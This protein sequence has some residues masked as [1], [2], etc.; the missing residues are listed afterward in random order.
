MCMQVL[1]SHHDIPAALCKKGRKRCRSKLVNQYVYRNV[2]SG[3]NT[4]RVESRACCDVCYIW[5][6]LSR[7]FVRMAL[8][9]TG[10]SNSNSM[11]SPA[12]LVVSTLQDLQVQLRRMEGKQAQMQTSLDEIKD[13]LK[14]SPESN[15]KVKGS[16]FQVC[17]EIKL[18]LLKPV[19][20]YAL[21]AYDICI[22]I[23]HTG[24]ETV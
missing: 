3:A 2:H 11:T 16:P 9:S 23:S 7:L 22:L 17:C 15:F 20:D 19:I 6:A 14:P 18:W 1:A 24:T 12:V 21:Y 10:R 13:L 5:R 8:G 4:S